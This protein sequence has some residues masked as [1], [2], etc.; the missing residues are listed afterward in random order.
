MCRPF[1]HLVSASLAIG[2][3]AGLM[4]GPACTDELVWVD[5]DVTLV[6]QSDSALGPTALVLG[7][8]A[9]PNGGVPGF[10]PLDELPSLPIV[11]GLQGGT[12]TM[13]TLR[14]ASLAP[15]LTTE[16]TLTAGEET[17]GST[18]LQL[19]TRPATTGPSSGAGWVEIP[20]L[21]IATNRAP[22]LPLAELEGRPATLTCVVT[23]SGLTAT[24]TATRPLDTP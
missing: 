16:C 11:D 4:L 20:D 17:L 8:R 14:V 21:P 19:P 9:N 3:A 15:S 10:A 5:P 24:A 7:Y 18:R 23:A 12:W 22:G 1:T 6:G 2:L 13:P